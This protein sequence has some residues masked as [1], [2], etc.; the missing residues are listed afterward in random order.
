MSF[1]LPNM[2]DTGVFLSYAREDKVMAERILAALEARGFPMYFDQY[3]PAG[4][5]WEKAIKSQLSRAYAVVGLWSSHS[6]QSKWVPVEAAAGL[7]KD[8]LFPILIEPAISLPS[9]FEHL[10][11]A[12]LS[13]W[14]GKPDDPKF[15]RA[16]AL[17]E[18]L[19]DSQVGTRRAIK[20]LRPLRLTKP[21]PSN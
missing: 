18:V 8:R 15:G 5:E 4:A 16:I 12:D 20:V 19:W 2:N 11:A 13:D 7:E 6:Q 3:I 17:L 1:D 21:R 10:Q 14:N 9:D